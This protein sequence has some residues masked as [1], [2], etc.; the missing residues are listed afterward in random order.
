MAVINLTM[1]W[2]CR[3]PGNGFI[4]KMWRSL[5][6]RARKALMRWKQ[7]LMGHSGECLGD[8]NA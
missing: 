2:W 1:G 7:G 5:V 4:V 3:S 8:K 6:L